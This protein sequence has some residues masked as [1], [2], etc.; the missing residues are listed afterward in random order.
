MGL[1]WEVGCG[2]FLGWE[3]GMKLQIFFTLVAQSRAIDEKNIEK[4]QTK[5]IRT[6]EKIFLSFTV[7][8][9]RKN[10]F[11]YTLPPSLFSSL[12]KKLSN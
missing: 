6:L 3:E 8:Y 11:I 7:F 9:I 1:E 4:I 2:E 10:L 5:I 12:Q